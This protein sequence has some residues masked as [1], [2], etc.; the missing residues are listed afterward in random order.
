MQELALELQP[1]DVSKLLLSAETDKKPWSRGIREVSFSPSTKRGHLCR[2]EA[3]GKAGC[4]PSKGG[5]WPDSDFVMNFQAVNLGTAVWIL[6]TPLLLL[7][8]VPPL[9]V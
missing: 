6:H 5:H 2:A 4:N 8:I 9:L 3:T 7:Q 1:T